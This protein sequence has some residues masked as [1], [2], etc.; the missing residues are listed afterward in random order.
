MFLAVE[1]LV[2]V[3]EA[4]VGSDFCAAEAEVD[5]ETVLDCLIDL[6]FD[7]IERRDEGLFVEVAYFGYNT[8]G[9]RVDVDGGAEDDTGSI[10]FVTRKIAFAYADE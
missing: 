3:F 1:L 10:A 4:P 7:Q 9:D 2:E 8:F 5:V 6:F